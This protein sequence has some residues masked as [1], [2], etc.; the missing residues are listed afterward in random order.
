MRTVLLG[1][2]GGPK[3]G[4]LVE[5]VLP[6]CSGDRAIL[7]DVV[8]AATASAVAIDDTVPDLGAERLVAVL[9]SELGSVWGTVGRRERRLLVEEEEC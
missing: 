8:A 3:A 2:R 1:R 7:A 5:V 6:C 9:G 4:S